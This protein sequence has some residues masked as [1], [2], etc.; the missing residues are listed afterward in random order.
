MNF[1][2]LYIYIPAVPIEKLKGIAMEHLN[3]T[4]AIVDEDFKKR[5]AE[6]NITKSV[7]LNHFIIIKMYAELYSCDIEYKTICSHITDYTGELD[8]DG[9]LVNIKA[10]KEYNEVLST[11]TCY[12]NG[13]ISGRE[14]LCADEKVGS[15][16]DDG[17]ILRGGK[18]THLKDLSSLTEAERR[19]LL[20]IQE[21]A[22]EKLKTHFEGDAYWLGREEKGKD[23]EKVTKVYL[24][25]EEVYWIAKYPYY[26]ITINGYSIKIDAINGK[27]IFAEYAI[28][29]AG[30]DQKALAQNLDTKLKK[31]LNINLLFIFFVGVITVMLVLL[32]SKGALYVVAIVYG[33]ITLIHVYFRWEESDINYYTKAYEATLER[34]PGSNAVDILDEFKSYIKSPIFMSNIKGFVFGLIISWVIHIALSAVAIILTYKFIL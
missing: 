6:C 11:T 14:T 19:R 7:T 5:V 13:M 27:V 12:N 9:N 33:N 8:S 10:N 32:I 1:G 18:Y 28:S 24:K 29:K 23:F 31:I 15:Y 4:G 30:L 2:D 25:H 20:K 22:A 26:E 21:R 17:Y 16:F 34:Q 3:K